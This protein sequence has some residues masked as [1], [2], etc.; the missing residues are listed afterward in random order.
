MK[1]FKLSTIAISERFRYIA[2]S[3]TQHAPFISAWYVFNCPKEDAEGKDF[4]LP[5]TTDGQAYEQ[6]EV[7]LAEQKALRRGMSLDDRLSKLNLAETPKRRP[8]PKFFHLPPAESPAEEIT[9][10]LTEF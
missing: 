8:K 4:I 1:K 3:I 7:E 10:T 2:D 5:R 9:L 6:Y